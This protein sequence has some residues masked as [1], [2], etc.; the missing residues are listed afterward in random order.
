ME[1][2][3]VSSAHRS[4]HVFDNN[5]RSVEGPLSHS[6]SSSRGWDSYGQLEKQAAFE[7]KLNL[8]VILLDADSCH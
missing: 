3:G 8:L 7:A 5:W 6:Q 4:P 1:A 2:V